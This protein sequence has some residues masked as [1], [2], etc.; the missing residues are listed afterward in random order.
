METTRPPTALGAARLARRLRPVYVAAGLQNV[1]LWVPVEKLFMTSIGF[2]TAAIGVMAAVYAVVVPL[3][4]VPS[5]I[6]ADRWSRRGVLIV[7][8]G[9][10]A[11]S[12]T[13]GGL[14][15][16]VGWYLVAAA[17][18]GVS[19]AMDSGTYESMV[20]DAVVEETGDGGP[21]ERAIGRVRL[22]QS[23]ALVVGALAGG[24]VA[25]VLSPRAAYFLTLPWI[26]CAA[27]A[28]VLFREPSLHRREAPEP[29]RAQVA[30][31]Y[32][33][34]LEPGRLRSV[35]A[36][37]VL[38]AVLMQ[39]VFEF[40]PVW[41][42]ALDVPPVAYGPQWAGLTLA[43]GVGAVL[44]ARPG[45]LRRPVLAVLAVLPVGACLLLAS[46]RAALLVV[47]AQV[48]VIGVSATVG[49]PLARR[50]HD[51]IPSALRAGVASG[52]STLSWLVFLPLSLAIGLVGDRAGIDAAS[53]LLVA[54]TG[55]GAV[56]VGPALRAPA[57]R[58]FPAQ[59]FRPADD[60]DWPGHWVT[61]PR[62]WPA[63]LGDAQAVLRAAV[64]DLPADQQDVLV[65]RDVHGRSTAE[66][67]QLIG[68]DEA[69]A[70]ALLHRARAHVRDQ[71]DDHLASRVD[72]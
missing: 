48:V 29:I 26:G 69:I 41:L 18:L 60:P 6:L 59:R 64:D 42:V 34:L 45:V 70:R 35:I 67:A 39:A 62:D 37:M 32:R 15:Q 65:A 16:D 38:G 13:V 50:L 3:L 27:V 56:L 46:S 47:A 5:G 68:T 58:T 72:P 71:L 54:V 21:F 25:E 30:A 23:V 61:P 49:V 57:T 17:L 55:A 52:V 12:V 66:T 24:V 8:L 11:A 44:G 22:V 1:T 10:L 53:W 33:T 2:S 63:D 20:Y 43:L 51:G 19:F 7:A 14:S 4:E 9:A 40:G 31:T 28:V 36:L